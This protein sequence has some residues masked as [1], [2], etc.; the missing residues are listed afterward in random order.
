MIVAKNGGH[1]ILHLLV[2]H[3]REI[4]VIVLF[5]IDIMTILQDQEI[6]KEGHDHIFLDIARL[7]HSIS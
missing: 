3:T 7:V 5:M 1:L 4:V 6:I 2:D